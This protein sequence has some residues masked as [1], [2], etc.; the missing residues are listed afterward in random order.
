MGPAL[1]QQGFYGSLARVAVEVGEFAMTADGKGADLPVAHVWRHDNESSLGGDGI[2]QYVLA[3]DFS[4]M[5]LD[6]GMRP[7]PCPG[8]FADEFAGVDEAGI[9]KLVPLCFGFFRKAQIDIH[10]CDL[11]CTAVS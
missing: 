7:V 4:N 9:G 10:L 8:T 6:S 1:E 3:A 11:S 5:L 2:I